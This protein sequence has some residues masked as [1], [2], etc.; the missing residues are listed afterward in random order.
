MCAMAH[1]DLFGLPE[2]PK[3]Q[4]KYFC[5]AEFVKADP[6]CTMADMQ[7]SL[8]RLLDKTR[9]LAGIPMKINSA[10][11][12]KE[13]ERSRGRNGS[14]SHCKGLAVD[15]SCADSV[16]RMKIVKAA[17]QCGFPRIGIYPTFVHLDCDLEKPSC[18]WL[19]KMQF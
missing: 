3:Y 1:V 10:Y 11:R 19:G 16:K 12:S 9:S 8:L 2:V 7:E 5:E 13:H 4:P 17:L 18:I 14:S 6:S 15:I